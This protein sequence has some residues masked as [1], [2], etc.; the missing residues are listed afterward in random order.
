MSP[1]IFKQWFTENLCVGTITRSD[2]LTVSELKDIVDREMTIQ[3]DKGLYKIAGVN[4]IFSK[5]FDYGDDL[6]GYELTVEPV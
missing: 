5:S 4:E 3:T 2:K 1:F 6:R